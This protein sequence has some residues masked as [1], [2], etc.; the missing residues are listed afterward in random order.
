MSRINKSFKI[1]SQNKL[2]CFAEL[3]FPFTRI[4]ICNCVDY[5]KFNPPAISNPDP[6]K[7][8]SVDIDKNMDLNFKV[9]NK[10]YEKIA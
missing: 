10:D 5:C 7:Y 9:F 8:I 2:K 3:Y 6:S 4:E 1:I